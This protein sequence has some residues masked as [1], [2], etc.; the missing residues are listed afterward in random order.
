[1]LNRKQH[2]DNQAEKSPAADA[3]R[4]QIDQALRYYQ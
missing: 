2:N 3:S 1:M 4:A